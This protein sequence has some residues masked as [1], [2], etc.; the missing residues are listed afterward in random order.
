MGEGGKGEKEFS[1]SDL[2]NG[3]QFFGSCMPVFKRVEAWG[4]KDS[5]LIIFED[6]DCSSYR[7]GKGKR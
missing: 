3:I 7:R 4:R 1:F 2:Q 6:A 5:Y